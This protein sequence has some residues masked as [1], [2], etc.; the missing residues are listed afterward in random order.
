MGLSSGFTNKNESPGI[1]V[2]SLVCSCDVIDVHVTSVIP[3][4][5]FETRMIYFP[6]WIDRASFEGTYLSNE[7]HLVLSYFLF[8]LTPVSTFHC[9]IIPENVII[10]SRSI[11]R[12]V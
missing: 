8:F 3:I 12:R 7:R 2:Y 5:K 9:V 6:F 1:L 11:W 10:P 4:V